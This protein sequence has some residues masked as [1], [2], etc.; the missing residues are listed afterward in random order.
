MVQ[1][2]FPKT[3]TPPPKDSLHL[4]SNY[5]PGSSPSLHKAAP[6]S[7]SESIPLS[8]RVG[9]DSS[10]ASRHGSLVDV[11]YAN[12]HQLRVIGLSMEQ[13]EAVVRYRVSQCQH[14]RTKEEIR[15][16]HQI[17]EATWLRVKSR[18]TLVPS[19][20]DGR[21]EN[22]SQ[23]S[24]KSRQVTI[25]DPTPQYALGRP[26]Q[27]LSSGDFAGKLSDNLDTKQVGEDEA[28]LENTGGKSIV[29]LNFSNYHELCVLGMSKTQALAVI[30]YRVKNGKFTSIEAIKNVSGISE[31]DYQRVKSRLT[32]VPNTSYSRGNR[33]SSPK[34][35]HVSG[36]K[37][38]FLACDAS[39]V[40]QLWHSPVK[41]L[42]AF[43]IGSHESAREPQSP[44]TPYRITPQGQQGLSQRGADVGATN[45]LC[46]D[47]FTIERGNISSPSSIK[48]PSFPKVQRPLKLSGAKSSGGSIRVASWNL[49]CF[50]EK[51]VDIPAVL[52]VVC[53]TILQNG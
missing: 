17:D 6:R 1:E 53:A 2:L 4:N 28:A 23:K 32:L 48:S 33:H 38:N 30:D 34:K 49:Q 19:G 24:P 5:N 39:P 41:I 20:L 11:N 10:P 42:P 51:K 52:E 3:S 50:N 37:K 15:N 36:R 14:F 7:P 16:V 18:L 29:D 27:Y 13:A 46:E 25:G 40:H 35:N 45:N 26:A 43:G 47:S 31:V 21:T 12:V 22:S 8:S 44:F 9:Y